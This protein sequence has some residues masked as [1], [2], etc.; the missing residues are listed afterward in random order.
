M[1]AYRRV[2]DFR[3]PAGLLPVHRNQLQTQRS[4]SSMG[5]PLPFIFFMEACLT[6]TWVRCV[7]AL[8]CWKENTYAA[9]HAADHWQQFLRQQHASLIGLLHACWFQAQVLWNKVGNGMTE[10]RYR[11][12]DLTD[13]LKAGCMHSALMSHCMVCGCQWCV[14][15]I[16]FEF[17]WEPQ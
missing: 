16:V 4:V 3:S 7:G 13:L 1:A 2:D 5:K 15:R 14:F 9:M 10:F 6:V 12:T 11:N 17:L 8:S